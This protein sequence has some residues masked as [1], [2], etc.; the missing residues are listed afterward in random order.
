MRRWVL[1][2][3]LL[4]YPFQVAL[5]MADKCCVTTAA[6]VTHHVAPALTMQDGTL[7]AAPQ[8]VFLADDDGLSMADPHCP[9]CMFGHILTL[10]SEAGVIPA[11]PHHGPAVAAI[12]SLRDSLPAARPERPKW[13]AAAT[14]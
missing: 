3:L 13:P 4:V 1:I 7:S 8:P 12:P 14:E 9:A 2:L 5:A 6:G 10:P 11:R